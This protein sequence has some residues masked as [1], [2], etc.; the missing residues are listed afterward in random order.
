MS[1]FRL[2]VPLLVFGLTIHPSARADVCLRSVS[3]ALA[4]SSETTSGPVPFDLT[5]TAL[6]FDRFETRPP[7][8]S[9]KT[10]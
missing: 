7:A 9:L 1:N 6:D 4:V 3:E 10:S 2:F 8:L 5:G